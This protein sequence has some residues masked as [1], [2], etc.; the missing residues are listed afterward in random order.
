MLTITV[1]SG[2]GG[3]GDSETGELTFFDALDIAANAQLD[4]RIVFAD[5]VDEV[6]GVG[7]FW[8]PTPNTAHVIDGDRDGDGVPDVTFRADPGELFMLSLARRVD[9]TIR[10]VIF[11]GLDAEAPPAPEKADD[12]RDGTTVPW[13]QYDV[14]RND[15]LG[16]FGRDG[17]DGRHSAP[18][19]NAGDLTLEQVWF[20][21]NHARSQAGGAGGDGGDGAGAESFPDAGE[22]RDGSDGNDGSN[23]GLGGDGGDGGHAA[24][25][26]VNVTDP[27]LSPANLSLRD[28]VFSNGSAVGADGAAGGEGGNGGEGAKG[29]KGGFGFLSGDAGDGGDGGDGGPGGRGGLGGDGGHASAAIVSDASAISVVGGLGLT[30]PG[31]TEAGDGVDGGVGGR[32]GSGGSGGERGDKTIGTPVAGFG[33]FGDRGA[34]FNTT[35]GTPGEDGETDDA[36][37]F[38]P[39]IGNSPPQRPDAPF[40]ASLVYAHI[41]RDEAVEGQTFK[42]SVVRA[43][44]ESKRLAVTWSLADLERG[45]VERGQDLNGSLVF[46]AGEGGA[47]TIRVRLREDGRVEGDEAFAFNLDALSRDDA[48][49][50]TREV[51]GTVVDGQVG[52]RGADVMRG[53]NGEDVLIGR[54]GADR[55]IGRGG[56]DELFGGSGDDDLRGG[57]TGDSLK[58]G[59]GDDALRGGAENDTLEGGGGEDVIRGGSGGDRID[60]GG[61]A[62]R[63][64]GGGGADLFVFGEGQSGPAGA[65]RDLVED[66]LP[67]TDDID[68]F[69]RIIGFTFI[70]AA[71]FSGT[72]GEIRATERGGRLLVQGD[73]DGDGAADVAVWLVGPDAPLTA[74]DFV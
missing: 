18:I 33:S 40:R 59:G 6:R 67:G 68:L 56:F 22:A 54:G 5:G 9:V 44:D 10:G 66:F 48:A 57:G 74:D 53:T 3:R 13:F 4:T 43:G 17:E 42:V 45:D 55:L 12:G 37:V 50:G 41:A 69:A 38:D 65:D 30:N 52:T 20:I 73:E 34:S 70:D 72:A 62:D 36:L 64:I 24:G 27:L 29:S 15:R 11:T 2:A 14:R 46:R 58:G 19:V 1:N 71:A 28:V 8:S 63:L 21:D 49:L 32:G 60:G 25:G 7:H 23:G 16:A 51:E 35:V 47:K 61:G 31:R 39:G 26:V